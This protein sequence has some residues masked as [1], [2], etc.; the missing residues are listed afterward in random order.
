MLNLAAV[1][2]PEIPL[3]GHYAYARAHPPL[4]PH[5]HLDIF[6]LCLLE[7]GTQP[8]VA[9]SVRYT[10]SGGDLFITKPGE[11]HGTGREPENKGQLYWLQF[12]DI[13][14]GRSFLQ[15]T[16]G[17][18]AT[19]MARFRAL[20]IRHVR[21]AEILVPTFERILA[22]GADAPHP[23]RLADVRNLVLRLLLDVLHLA[24]HRMA[25][26][27]SIGIQQAIRHIEQHPD[28]I[29]SAEELARQARMSAS[30]FKAVFKR[31]TRMP[32]VEYAAW[33]RI[34]R[35]KQ[36]LRT[37][38]R[39]VTRLAMDLGFATSQHFATVFKRFTGL[40]PRAFRQ[41]AHLRATRQTPSCGAGPG[42]H[43]TAH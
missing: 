2:L 12:R 4:A 20:S 34:E 17:E 15:L 14:P 25:H 10:L 11:V 16:P 43:P 18:T 30:H 27:F 19:L 8:Y 5:L 38:D 13:P 33:R 24:G 9:G 26:P 21:H 1:G 23:L 6:E 7:R 42:F 3:V 41:R 22:A 36:L 37:T 31:E 29:P 35:A 40:T 32:P 39:P 28:V